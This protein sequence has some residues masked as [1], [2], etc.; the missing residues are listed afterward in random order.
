MF[1]KMD[2]NVFEADYTPAESFQ[3]NK[4]IFKF[5]VDV[6][7]V[8]SSDYPTE[9]DESG[10]VNNVVVFENSMDNVNEK[11]VV[12]KGNEVKESQDTLVESKVQSN[13][14]SEVPKIIVS[15]YDTNT[16]FNVEKMVQ[17]LDITGAS[18]PNL[19]FNISP[20]NESKIP[21]TAL[22]GHEESGQLYSADS[23]ATL[24]E[25]VLTPEVKTNPPKKGLV[26]WVRIML[27]WMI[28]S[29]SL[30]VFLRQ[31]RKMMR[32]VLE[33]ISSSFFYILDF[34]PLNKSVVLRMNCF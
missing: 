30:S 17:G 26:G 34:L 22:P 16:E 31:S 3:E 7:W 23:E 13:V 12:L 8:T 15:N 14:E 32:S 1:K 20:S 10:N 27:I 29:I 33:R 25:E 28:K 24:K 2:N 19:E 21:K 18:V 11:E 5:V 6:N 9:T 4:F